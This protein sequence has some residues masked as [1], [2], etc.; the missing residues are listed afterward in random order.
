MNQT[1]DMKSLQKQEQILS[2]KLKSV[3]KKLEKARI[4]EQEILKKFTIIYDFAPL[5]FF[6]LDSTG[7]IQEMNFTGAELLRDKR[8]ALRGSPFKLFVS[9]ESQTVFEQFMKS[10]SAGNKKELCRVHLGYDEQPPVDVLIEGVKTDT[11][12]TC[13]LSVLDYSRMLKKR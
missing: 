11:D 6:T 1:R 3:D 7:G 4:S 13:L 8:A 10:I 5:G 2:D 9:P 12:H